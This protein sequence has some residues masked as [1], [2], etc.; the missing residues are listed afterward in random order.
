[1]TKRLKDGIVQEDCDIRERADRILA[2]IGKAMHEIALR[3]REYNSAIAELTEWFEKQAH[4][5]RERLKRHEKELTALM[6]KN[7]TALFEGTD[8]VALAN[9]SL[10]H[11]CRDRVSIPRDALA[12][13]EDLGFNEVVKIAKSLDREAVE[14][15]PDERLF[16]IGA[17]RK[18]KDEYSYDLKKGD[19]DG[20]V[21][22][23]LM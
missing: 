5:S 13:C 16:L 12:K 8:V 6:K 18:P 17:E 1:M 10:I 21:Q 11:N 9:G 4:A 3:E 15:W 22:L 23:A 14:G 20:D 7:R 19:A 2:D